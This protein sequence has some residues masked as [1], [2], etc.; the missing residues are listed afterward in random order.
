MKGLL[1]W[2]SCFSRNKGTFWGETLGSLWLSRSTATDGLDHHREVPCW[3][4]KQV[5]LL[6]LLTCFHGPNTNP[7][8]QRERERETSAVSLSL[9]LPSCVSSVATSASSAALSHHAVGVS[10]VL[11]HCSSQS[12]SSTKLFPRCT[13]NDQ[14]ALMGAGVSEGMTLPLQPL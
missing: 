4:K 3:A 11:P 6:V 7:A 9:S 8:Y 12:L 5:K 2:K 1:I 14:K 10:F 13:S